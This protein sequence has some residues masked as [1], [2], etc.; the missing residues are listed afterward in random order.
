MGQFLYQLSLLLNCGC[1]YT[2]VFRIGKIFRKKNPIF[3][4]K[5]FFSV[6]SL[7]SICLIFVPLRLV[8]NNGSYE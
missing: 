5:Y 6:M 3:R 4:T 1:K 2:A 7:L 8:C